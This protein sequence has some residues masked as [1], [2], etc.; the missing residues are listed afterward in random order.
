MGPENKDIE[1]SVCGINFRRVIKSVSGNRER[2]LIDSVLGEHSRLLRQS[3]EF[4]PEHSGPRPLPHNCA[5]TV[6]DIQ[7]FSRVRVTALD[8]G[9]QALVST[10]EN[11]EDIAVRFG[12]FANLLPEAREE[13]TKS[14]SI[15]QRLVANV[16][17]IISV[18]DVADH[19]LLEDLVKN[20]KTALLI[21]LDFTFKDI[22]RLF[23][24]LAG[25]RPPSVTNV[26]KS[27]WEKIADY[28]LAQ[29]GETLALR[30]E[31]YSL[32]ALFLSAITKR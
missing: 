2:G 16:S 20:W 18:E 23:G 31:Q 14:I 4:R 17:D 25:P 10:V 30:L 1:C 27:V 13:I 12:R 28:F 5:K 11:A 21:S 6:D 8:F 3:P 7:I 19:Y 29:S 9:R 22:H 32:W 15:L 24:F 26:Y